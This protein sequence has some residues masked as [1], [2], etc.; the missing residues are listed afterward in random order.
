[1]DGTNLST[2][3]GGLMWLSQ[4]LEYEFGSELTNRQRS[5]DQ[6]KHRFV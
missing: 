5:G 1:M 3:V 4:T 2:L 6:A